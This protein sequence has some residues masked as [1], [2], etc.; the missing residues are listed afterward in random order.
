MILIFA[1]A[2]VLLRVLYSVAEIC[3]ER[4]WPR[5]TWRGLITAIA[6]LFLCGSAFG[7]VTNGRWDWVADTT[8]GTGQMLPVLALPGAYVQFFINCTALPC[9]TPAVTYQGEHSSSTCPATTPVVWQY[10]VGTGCKATADSNGNFGG[11]F[12]TGSYQYVLTISGHQN[13]PYAFDVGFGGGGGVGGC[14]TSGLVGQAQG[15]NGVGGCT[16]IVTKVNGVA[17]TDAALPNFVDTAGMGGISFQKDSTHQITAST[18]P[19]AVQVEDSATGVSQTTIDFNSTTP[20]AP[21]GGLQTASGRTIPQ[22]GARVA[23]F[24]RPALCFRWSP[25]C[26]PQA[27]MSCSILPTVP[28]Q[29]ELSA[30][31]LEAGDSRF[32]EQVGLSLEETALRP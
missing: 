23:T 24:L 4:D 18:I 10:P 25:P 26:S 32:R 11:W 3:F 27:N 2:L 31:T 8:T 19:L 20:A 1:C 28:A 22:P 14:T 16:P 12:Q 13:G 5:K 29:P 7:Q 9:T 6:L 17:L 30:P 15:A 21:A